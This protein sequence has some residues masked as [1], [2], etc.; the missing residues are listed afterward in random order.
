MQ[1]Q[2]TIELKDLQLFGRHGWHA[3]EAST[4]NTFIVNIAVDFMPR[5]PVVTDI[6]ETI[7]YATIYNLAKE[8]FKQ[9]QALLE[10]CAMLMAESI[11]RH[12][13]QVTGIA[14]SIY[15]MAA[16]IANFSGTVGITYKKTF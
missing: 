3:E 2:L 4:G 6:D 15:K 5:V 8:I 10:T 7:N 9:P 11:Q 14:I 12:F 1:Q 13:P 16:P